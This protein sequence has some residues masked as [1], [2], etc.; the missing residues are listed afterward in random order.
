MG[1]LTSVKNMVIYDQAPPVK[2]VVRNRSETMTVRIPQ[3]H[4][5]YHVKWNS[6]RDDN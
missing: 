4:F 2:F 6:V 5:P 3:A 1:F